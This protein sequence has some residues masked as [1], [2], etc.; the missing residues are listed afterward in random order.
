[1]HLC[2]NVSVSLCALC[3]CVNVCVSICV[4]MYLR[5]NISVSLCDSV[6]LIACLSMCLSVYASM[7]VCVRVSGGHLYV[8]M[9]LCVYVSVHV[10]ICVWERDRVYVQVCLCVLRLISSYCSCYCVSML[11]IR[12][13]FTGFITYRSHHSQGIQ[14]VQSLHS[15]L[16]QPSAF[17]SMWQIDRHILQPGKLWLKIESFGSLHIVSLIMNSNHWWIIYKRRG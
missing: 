2:V 1:M 8:Y 13:I 16:H 17:V 6:Y 3:L 4:F 15:V 14:A 5:V 12:G 11:K 7:Y 9:S 10:Y